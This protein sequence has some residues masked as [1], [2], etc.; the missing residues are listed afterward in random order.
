MVRRVN[1]SAILAFIFIISSF[2][3]VFAAQKTGRRKV[4][5]C[6]KCSAVIRH[7]RYFIMEGKNYCSQQCLTWSLPRCS[8]CGTP[9]DKTWFSADF[10]QKKYCRNC[11]DLP[12]CTSC[13]N[14]ASQR[15]PGNIIIC[16][17]CEKNV[18]TT[19]LPV[20]DMFN[21]LRKELKNVLGI[22][23][24]HRIRFSLVSYSGLAQKKGSPPDRGQRGLFRHDKQMRK[25]VTYNKFT[26][27]TLSQKTTLAKEDFSIYVLEYLPLMDF[28]HT[29]IHELTHDWM[30]QYFPYI[31]EPEIKEGTC[32][33]IAW[34]FLQKT[35]PDDPEAKIICSHMERNPDPIY[36]GGFRM[37][38]KIANKG[39]STTQRI[40]RLKA[41][42]AGQK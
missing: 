4:T 39:S 24:N 31:R 10:P 23:T 26:G 6:A 21:E 25:E 12:L 37:I 38:R 32:E 2:V 34:L 41:Y 18:V 22:G 16:T 13:G 1:F 9:A 5:V 29:V 20:Q 27:K 28:R 15:R 8:N 17:Q 33:Y 3:T 19:A 30:S 14:I 40:K 11:K 36:G 42:L 7:G 35:A